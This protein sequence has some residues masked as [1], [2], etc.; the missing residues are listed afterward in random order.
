MQVCRSTGIAGIVKWKKLRGRPYFGKPPMILYLVFFVTGKMIF[1][2][3]ASGGRLS[4]R[5]LRYSSYGAAAIAYPCSAI[6]RTTAL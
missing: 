6:Q 3:H 2:S 5:V 4:K 1:V